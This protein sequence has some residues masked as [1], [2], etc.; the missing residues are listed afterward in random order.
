[1]YTVHW[2][3]ETLAEGQDKCKFHN[4][5]QRS[6]CDSAREQWSTARPPAAAARDLTLWHHYFPALINTT[7]S[8]SL[9]TLFWY[10]AFP[11]F[12]FLFFCLSNRIGLVWFGVDFRPWIALQ[13]SGGVL[14]SS[15]SCSSCALTIYKAGDTSGGRSWATG[16]VCVS[17]LTVDNHKLPVF[18]QSWKTT[19]ANTRSAKTLRYSV[20]VTES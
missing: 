3:I 1:M 14:I 4:F 19:F 6:F 8:N 7:R 15:V 13:N 11:Q 20:A 16:G 2:D 17:P 18:P 10:K 9:T 12:L 5:H